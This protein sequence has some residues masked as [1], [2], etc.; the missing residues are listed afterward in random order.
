MK[1]FIIFT[2]V[3]I[4]LLF[5]GYHLAMGIGDV[6]RVEE[7]DTGIAA[8]ANYIRLVVD[9]SES[10]WNTAAPQE[11]MS[12][13]GSCEYW[14]TAVCST[15]VAS[16]SS[17]S[18]HFFYPMTS[19]KALSLL[20][21]DIDAGEVLWD[22]RAHDFDATTAD[23]AEACTWTMYHQMWHGT[24]HDITGAAARW[25]FDIDDHA[26]TGGIIVI[27]LY[28]RPLTTGSSITVGAGA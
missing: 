28:W 17:D 9:F 18:I 25:D 7:W 15:N 1:R 10:A 22:S 13:L 23:P 12:I 20:A 24:V 3:S 5:G 27:I 26:F 4:A 8:H 6:D 21:E 2:L 11:F 16:T 19:T 14:M